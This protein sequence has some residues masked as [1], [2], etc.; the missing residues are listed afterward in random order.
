MTSEKTLEV[1]FKIGAELLIEYAPTLLKRIKPSKVKA[2]TYFTIVFNFYL[3]EDYQ[4]AFETISGILDN[5]RI[6]KLG[7]S[8]LR[9]GEFTYEYWLS[10]VPKQDYTP[11]IVV[12]EEMPDSSFMLNH[13][14]LND[15][16]LY[17][18]KASSARLYMWPINMETPIKI[19]TLK[20]ML[21][22]IY[23][24]YKEISQNIEDK[25]KNGQLTA[26]KVVLYS[27][28]SDIYEPYKNKLAKI[29]DNKKIR[30]NVK[31]DLV[32]GKFEFLID[33]SSIIN[34]IIKLFGGK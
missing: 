23:E 19:K 14:V 26:T 25:V 21:I 8:F 11:I 15:E 29:L 24:F 27:T 2:R 18:L 10:I 20:K 33:D 17:F 5:Y 9:R 28:F 16:S 7:K 6:K 22:N 3:G 1:A 31:I 12:L 30:D 4:N 13:Y 34:E 32:H